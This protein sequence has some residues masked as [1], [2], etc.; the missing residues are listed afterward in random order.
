MAQPLW[1]MHALKL[2][3]HFRLHP[4][5]SPEAS[6]VMAVQ[7]LLQERKSSLQTRRLW[8]LA[9]HADIEGLTD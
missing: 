1:W 2:L 8:L 3:Q 5:M 9:E 6:K 4:A 7:M